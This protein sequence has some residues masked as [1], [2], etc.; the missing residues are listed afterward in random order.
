MFKLV[1]HCDMINSSH[2]RVKE[3]SRFL[4]IP[5]NRLDVSQHSLAVMT[6]FITAFILGGL[7]LILNSGFDFIFISGLVLFFIQDWFS[8]IG[9]DRDPP[10]VEDP[11]CIPSVENGF[12]CPNKLITV[13]LLSSFQIDYCIVIILTFLFHD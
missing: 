7:V 12:K 13:S 1:T 2:L 9:I 6:S 8:E 10:N 4:Q 5:S 11:T 3:I